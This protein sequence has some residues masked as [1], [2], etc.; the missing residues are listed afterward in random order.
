M[1][2]R[3][4]KRGRER[5]DGELRTRSVRIDLRIE[6]AEGGHRWKSGAECANRQHTHEKTLI[7]IKNAYTRRLFM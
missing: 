3:E 7:H 1:E 6:G 5:K 2:R 4:K